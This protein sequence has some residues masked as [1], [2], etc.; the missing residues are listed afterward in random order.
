MADIVCMKR[1]N[2]MVDQ[3]LLEKARE[4]TG[5]R[6]YSATVNTALEELVREGRFRKRLEEWEKLA[7]EGPIFREGYLEEIRPK[8]R[9][10]VQER[11]LHQDHAD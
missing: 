8:G 6:T 4:A 5:D 1:T 11:T 7:A 3:E 10:L 9:Q 2:L